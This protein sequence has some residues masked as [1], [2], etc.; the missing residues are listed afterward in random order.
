MT[1]IGPK[2]ETDMTLLNVADGEY[3]SP[4]KD[5]HVSFNFSIEILCEYDKY[6]DICIKPRATLTL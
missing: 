1:I 2:F 6:S 5:N 3:R 4:D